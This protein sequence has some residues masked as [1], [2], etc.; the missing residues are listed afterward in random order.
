MEEIKVTWYNHKTKNVGETTVEV[1]G[2]I[3]AIKMVRIINNYEILILKAE[4]CNIEKLIKN[5]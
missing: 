5:L 2:L 4:Y 3:K 1:F